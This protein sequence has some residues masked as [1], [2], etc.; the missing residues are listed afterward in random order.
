[1]RRTVASLVVSSMLVFAGGVP[2][3]ALDTQAVV[4]PF[5]DVPNTDP[6]AEAI[7]WLAQE[8]ITLG[9]NPPANDRFCPGDV[10]TRGQMAAFLVRALDLSDRGSVDFSDDDGSV[11]EAEIERLATAGI[12][13]GCNPP[14]NDRFCPEDAVTRE[15]MA[16]FLH[17]ALPG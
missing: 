10:V 12:T 3:V 2:A 8:G 7:V 1:M 5:A 9:C 15:Q 14:V 13:L 6:F 17:R 16:A 4:S 11:F